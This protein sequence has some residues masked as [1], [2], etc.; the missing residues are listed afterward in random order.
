MQDGLSGGAVGPF[1]LALCAVCQRSQGPHTHALP[2]SGYDHPHTHE[3]QKQG[4][5]REVRAV[6]VVAVNKCKPRWSVR[7]VAPAQ[8]S[9]SFVVLGRARI[10]PK[11]ERTLALAHG[12]GER[13]KRQWSWALPPV[14]PGPFPPIGAGSPLLAS[15]DLSC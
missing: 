6:T 14:T 2:A 8:Q 3:D 1:H 9:E 13:G 10:Q 4:P 15:C 11:A 12:L 7:C 5:P